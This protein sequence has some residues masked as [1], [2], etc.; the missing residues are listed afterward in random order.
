MIKQM[1]NYLVLWA[2]NITA[3]SPKAAA[4]QARK[5]QIA[6]GTIAQVFEIYDEET[7]TP[8][9]TVDLKPPLRGA[10]LDKPK[11]IY[12]KPH[13]NDSKGG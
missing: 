7:L 13:T 2:M 1:N 4:K 11:P 5:A 10:E 3:D 8:I 9:E 6:K 12:I